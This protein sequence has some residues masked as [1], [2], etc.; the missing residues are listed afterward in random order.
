MSKKIVFYGS[1]SENMQK[2]LQSKCPE[3]FDTLLV[4]PQQDL[5][6]LADA[7]YMI[8]R[9]GAVDQRVLDAAPRLK[10][11]Q[12]W[13]VGYDK[14]DIQAAG[15]RGI[16]VGICVGGNSMPVAELAVSLM[17]D[18]LRN[19]LPLNEQMKA[20]SWD[21]E[22]FSSRSYL[23]HGK[24]VGLIGIGNIARKVAAIVRGG[25]DARVLYYDVFRL[26]A[27]QEEALGVTYADLDTLMAESDLI[28]VHVPLLDSTR[29][30][31]D[32]ARLVQMKPTACIINTSRG[33]VIREAD[34]ID[35]LQRGQILGAGLDTFEEEPL[36][37]DSPLL[38]L[39][40]VVT[41]PHC[42]GNTADN[43][44]NMAAICMDCIARYDAA[45]STEMREIVN[46]E[47][48]K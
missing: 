44:V 6:A 12:K 10:W 47:F 7:D 8:N 26:D 38:H 18:V 37:E 31:I 30:M 9:A 46:R 4:L 24:T 28:S 36:P 14:I 1:F 20:G 15:K 39:E 33:G 16:P 29:G 35:A 34:L 3:G 42:G 5:S 17:L 13:G 19:V 27:A 25:F 45:P 22:R 23:L 41:T 32:A 40:N 48:L 21:R 2:A 11:I 43:D